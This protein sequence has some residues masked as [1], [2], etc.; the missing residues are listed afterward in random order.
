MGFILISGIDLIIITLMTA[1]I[2][3]SKLP[4]F[5]LHI[6][7]PKVHVEASILG[8]IVLAG[9]V[10]KAGSIFC[11]IFCSEL[12]V[13][14]VRVVVGG[15]MLIGSDRKVVIAY[16]SVVHM[17]CCVIAFGLLTMYRGYSHVV[18]SPLMFVMV[19]IGYQYSGS[20]LL[21]P[22]FGS[23]ILGGLLL[24]N[25]GFPLLRAFYGEVIWFSMLGPLVVIF[26][27]GYFIMGIVSIRLFYN[28]KGYEWIPIYGVPLLL[29]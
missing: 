17:S 21:A 6:W 22:S 1:L 9:V 16:S 26:L 5:G 11:S 15:F 8:S 19:Y 4:V 10:L 23:L 20:R 14:I 24:F 7:L 3:F 29:L 28:A 13:L 18:V 12:H 25:L 27:I 2:G